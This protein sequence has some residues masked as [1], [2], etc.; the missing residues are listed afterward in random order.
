METVQRNSINKKQKGVEK[1]KM[2]NHPP[3][4]EE[5]LKNVDGATRP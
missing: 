4:P 2:K 1:P 3:A 5:L